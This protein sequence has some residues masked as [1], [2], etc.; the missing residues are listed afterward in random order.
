MPLTVEQFTERLTS[1]GIMSADELRDWIAAVPVEKQPSD[2]DSFADE[3]VRQSKLTKFQAEQ[4]IAGK[5]ASLTLGNYVLLDM[6]GQGGM[7]LVYRAW[8]RRMERVVALKVIAGMV[9]A[10]SSALQRFQREVVAA[11][12]LNHSNIVT[13]YDSDEF[14]GTCFLVMEY[15]DGHNL[16]TLVK[17]K[18]PLPVESAT[19]CVLQAARGLAFAH[20]HGVIHRDIKPSN[21][22]L[23]HEG[24]VKV[25]DMGLARIDA[26]GLN[27]VV[28]DKEL[29]TSGTVMGSIDYMSPEQ[30]VD[31]RQADAKSDQYSLGCTLYF[32][33]NGRSLYQGETEMLRLLAHREQPTPPL[34]AEQSEVP[35]SLARVFARMVAKR[36]EQRFPNMTEVIA[37]LE[38][39]LAEPAMSSIERTISLEQEGSRA[40][41]KM[42]V[43][44]RSEGGSPRATMDGLTE[45][46]LA[47]TRT[48][49]GATDTD[50]ASNVLSPS[51]ERRL[52]GWA[53]LRNDRR[54]WFAA[55][56]LIVVMGWFLFPPRR[57]ENSPPGTKMPETKT[58]EPPGTLASPSEGELVAA[59]STVDLIPLVN[60]ESLANGSAR[61]LS[62]QGDV[63]TLDASNLSRQMW[64]NF[65]SVNAESATI[66]TRC[67]FTK[68]QTQSFVKLVIGFEPEL[69]GLVGQDEDGAFYEIM[70]SEPDHPTIRKNVSRTFDAEF[71]EIA[72]I[73]SEDRL[74]LFVDGEL[75]LEGPRPMRAVGLVALVAS[76]CQVEFERPRVVVPASK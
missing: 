10:D 11:A 31:S 26:T 55:T 18:G 1:S 28:G 49:I 51:R 70:T 16:S 47:F 41:L 68:I 20:A 60:P 57:P 45:P 76:G 29:T 22:L 6:L 75:V 53:A 59:G 30:A 74:Q 34:E 64:L 43:G 52:R 3:L 14:K 58:P 37:A 66:R 39:C 69:Y 50:P 2:G 36:P 32:L 48:I 24:T 12:K 17:T 40:R 44:A 62:I 21:L 8:H 56:A 67:R 7:G 15:V 61:D 42:F 46:D 65:L 13:S 33:L 23:D 19:L 9:T 35:R 54:M 63:L 71:I 27:R 73:I 25:L 72:F 5:G 38:A 4:I